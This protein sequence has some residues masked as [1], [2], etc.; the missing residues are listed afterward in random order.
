MRRTATFEHREDD[1]KRERARYVVKPH[2][3]TSWYTICGTD[4][5]ETTVLFF[6]LVRFY[7][8]QTH[9]FIVYSRRSNRFN[10]EPAMP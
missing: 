8:S 2:G 10:V 1:R 3:R 5:L 9:L 7:L 6:E 4:A